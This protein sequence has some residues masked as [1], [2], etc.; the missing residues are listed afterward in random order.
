MNEV[1]FFMAGN[2]NTYKVFGVEYNTHFLIWYKI[3]TEAN[4]NTGGLVIHATENTNFFMELTG[5]AN[6]TGNT[7]VFRNGGGKITPLYASNVQTE[8]IVFGK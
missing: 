5:D 1:L 7:I 8:Y 6:M 2:L 3:S 4:F